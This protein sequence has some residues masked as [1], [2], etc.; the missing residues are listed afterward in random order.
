MGV[1]AVHQ[2]QDRSHEFW[3]QRRI[4]ISVID[5]NPPTTPN[6]GKG[7]HP[8]TRNRPSTVL[9]PTAPIVM[10]MGVVESFNDRKVA[11][12]AALMTIRVR[13]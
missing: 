12:V 1:P 10:N 2:L 13:R 11:V 7:P 9:R 5:E 8:N 4:L 3:A 6:L